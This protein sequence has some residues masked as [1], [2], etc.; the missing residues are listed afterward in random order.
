MCYRR[1]KPWPAGTVA[2]GSG[3][4]VRVSLAPEDVASKRDIVLGYRPGPD[5]QF[6]GWEEVISSIGFGSEGYI[7]QRVWQWLLLALY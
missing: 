2:K 5:S 1:C 3:D 4:C 6:F 7:T